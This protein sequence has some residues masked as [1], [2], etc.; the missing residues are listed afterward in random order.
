M[1]VLKSSW[2]KFW[3]PGSRLMW[4]ALCR[5]SS[6]KMFTNKKSSRCPDIMYQTGRASVVHRCQSC[7]R[8]WCRMMPQ[9]GDSKTGR[10]HRPLSSIL[11][12]VIEFVACLG[13]ACSLVYFWRLPPW[14]DNSFDC[15]TWIVIAMQ[16]V[17]V[18]T[19]MLS[20]KVD[21][22]SCLEERS[23]P[24]T[25]LLRAVCLH[26]AVY[27]NNVI[28]L[29]FCVLPV[30]ILSFPLHTHVLSGPTQK[31]NLFQSVT[32]ALD[33]TLASDPTAGEPYDCVLSHM[34]S[35][36]FSR[37]IRKYIFNGNVWHCN[38]EDMIT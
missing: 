7:R 23:I 29:F 6:T 15:K 31:M 8:W 12:P 5:P 24:R 28:S 33:N 14:P 1:W 22:R 36:S 16:K 10:G 9:E 20:Q 4:R 11:I 13:R 38:F 2:S 35:W 19:F 25:L 37:A 26:C 30:S 34:S 27:M 18:D 32:S 3:H 21:V 17:L